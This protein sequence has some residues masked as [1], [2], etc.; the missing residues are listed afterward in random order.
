TR[1]WT[2][3]WVRGRRCSR[4]TRSAGTLSVATSTPSRW[5]PRRSG[6]REP[7]GTHRHAGPDVLAVAS[8]EV[9]PAV[10]LRRAGSEAHRDRHRL[11][12]GVLAVRRAAGADRDAALDE[13]S[14]ERSDHDRA[15]EARAAARVFRRLP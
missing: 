8:A 10:S 6:C 7:R 3:S 1:L 14:E 12:R 2:R 13:G 9:D 5:R 15:R 11:V 4:R